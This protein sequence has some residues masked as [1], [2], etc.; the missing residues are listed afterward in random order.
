MYK[1]VSA[2]IN[3]KE[4]QLKEDSESVKEKLSDATNQQ[5]QI[6]A[7]FKSMLSINNYKYFTKLAIFFFYKRVCF[8][9]LCH[10]FFNKTLCFLDVLKEL[11]ED[12]KELEKRLQ[13]VEED[14]FE[15]WEKQSSQHDKMMDKIKGI[16]TLYYMLAR[17]IQE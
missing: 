16:V 10:T 13:C 3:T 4:S 12:Q 8:L 11:T 1:F 6:Q 2:A 17:W 15:L 7:E 5:E 9:N 14:Q